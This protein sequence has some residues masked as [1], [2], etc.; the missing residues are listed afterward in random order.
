M[1]GNILL[2]KLM[3]FLWMTSWIYIYFLVCFNASDFGSPATRLDG[4]VLDRCVG[5]DHN[6]SLERTDRFITQHYF[7]FY[8]NCLLL[9]F[10]TYGSN[11]VMDL[12]GI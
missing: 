1:S 4:I 2:M 6:P 8:S 7:S 10:W 11:G 3:L 9:G 5:V 12:W